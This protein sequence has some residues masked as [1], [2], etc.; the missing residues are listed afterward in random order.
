[1]SRIVRVI[2]EAEAAEYL[3]VNAHG[4][5][6]RPEPNHPT[7]LSG[8][9]DRRF[10]VFDNG[11][12]VG[13][14]RNFSMTLTMP[15]GTRVGAG[16]V[17]WIAVHPLHRRRGVMAAL[18]EALVVDS[19]Q[20]G[21]LA[22]I[23]TASEG[24]IYWSRGYGPATWGMAGDIDLASRATLYPGPPATGSLRLMSAELDNLPELKST[25]MPIFDAALERPGMVSRPDHW[26]GPYLH[27]ITAGPDYAICAIHTSAGVDDGYVIYQAQGGWSRDL[28]PE[29]VLEIKDFVTT[30]TQAHRSLWQHLLDRDL[31]RTIRVERLAASDPIRLMFTDV[32]A[33]RTRGLFE[34]LWIRPINMHALLSS[35]AYGPGS[36]VVIDV[37]GEV[38]R[39]SA[40]GVDRVDR[41]HS[42]ARVVD[43]TMG[44]A[45]LGAAILGGTDVGTLVAAGRAVEHRERGGND[46]SAVFRWSPDPVMLTNF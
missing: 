29:K 30:S 42:V 24:S 13:V 35:R 37:D 26:W 40:D 27:G 2:S 21:E 34:R 44:R 36:P 22:S 41:G 10:A 18:I 43:V 39:V 25:L 17:S 46:V 28:N 1:M 8:D 38:F 12:M 32:R 31:A 14:G 3:Q 33:F 11:E 45:A 23:L 6:I 9:D 19:Q 4:F 15:G 5:A 16:G 7:G 20:R